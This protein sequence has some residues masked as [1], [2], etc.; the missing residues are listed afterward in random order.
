MHSGPAKKYKEPPT[1][2]TVPTKTHRIRKTCT[3]PALSMRKAYIYQKMP[4]DHADLTAL[5][6]IV[7]K[8]SKIKE[9]Y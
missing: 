9:I 5:R 6:D 3:K 7:K 1:N 8:M 2:G 4:H